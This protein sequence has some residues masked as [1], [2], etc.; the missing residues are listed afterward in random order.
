MSRLCVR[1]RLLKTLYSLF[2]CMFGQVSLD[3]LHISYPSKHSADRHNSAATSTLH[4]NN[5][6]TSIV[7]SVGMFLF[8]LYHVT[9]II[10]LINMLIAMMSHSFEDIQVE[11]TN[12]T[13]IKSE[14]INGE[15]T[16]RLQYI[17]AMT[18]L[19]FSIATHQSA[20]II[21]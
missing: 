5:Q 1:D 11:A 13:A 21:E 9:I 19:V 6:A 15:L 8:A 3:S 10:V 16:L 18:Q 14:V 20:C 7:E 2:W 12:C 4:H 17:V